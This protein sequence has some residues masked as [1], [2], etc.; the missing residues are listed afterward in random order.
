VLKA[1]AIFRKREMLTSAALH[2]LY[3]PHIMDPSMYLFP[4]LSHRRLG[5]IG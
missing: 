1:K 3:I 5:E 4:I 2:N